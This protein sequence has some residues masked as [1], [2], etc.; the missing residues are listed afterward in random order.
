M[1]LRRVRRAQWDV[2]AV[3]SPRGE[4]PLLEFLGGLNAELAAD[5]RAMLR[6]LSLAS[7]QGPPRNTELSHK[8]AGEIWEFIAGRLR[9]LWFYDEGRVIVCSHGFM[10][11]TR[12][13]P[14]SE[15][16]RAQAARRGYRAAKW[17]RTL[18]VTE[19]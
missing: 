18:R 2:L 5:G 4:C 9:V 16:D 10:K 11:R 7:E 8:L 3:C 12:K 1:R 14:M 6:L 13:T 17:T 19:E 15:I